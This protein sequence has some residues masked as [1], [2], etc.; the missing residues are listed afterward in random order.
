MHTYIRTYTPPHIHTRFSICSRWFSWFSRF[1]RLYVY[2]YVYVCMYVCVCG[3]MCMC[4]CTNVCIHACLYHM[5]VCK[6]VY[7][8]TWVN[9]RVGEYVRT[10]YQASNEFTKW[11]H[12]RSIYTFFDGNLQIRTMHYGRPP[13]G[14][15]YPHISHRRMWYVRTSRTLRTMRTLLPT[16]VTVTVSVTVTRHVANF[17]WST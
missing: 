10:S 1:S 8:H 13:A 11:V 17:Y 7:K 15:L 2:V 16:T 9:G 14:W 12:V 4:V 6:H 3:C 5:Y